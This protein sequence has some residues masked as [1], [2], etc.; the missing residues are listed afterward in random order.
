[1]RTQAWGRSRDEPCLPAVVLTLG[2]ALILLAVVPPA[3]ASAL[4][5]A[6]EE[7]CA[8]RLLVDYAAPLT[9]LPKV[10]EP[11]RSG[12]LT[13]GPP[14]LRF[15]NF[16]RWPGQDWRVVLT[17]ESMVYA[18]WYQA[19][20]WWVGGKRLDWTVDSRLVRV[21]R[22]GRDLRLAERGRERIGVV[23]TQSGGGT[24]YR[25]FG[26][27]APDR[28]GIYRYDLVFRDRHGHLLGRLHD[29]YRVVRRNPES[30][31]IL[32]GTTFRRGDLVLGRVENPGTES[33]SFGAGFEFDRLSGGIWARVPFE[34]LF[35]FPNVVPAIAI[36]LGRGRSGDCRFNSFVV[37]AGMGPGIYRMV[38][39]ADLTAEFTVLP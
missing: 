34:E 18:F 3:A 5:S 23:S 20:F 13:F 32:D 33:V 16:N 22:G 6:Q 25:M 15:Q 14:R 26:L 30:R 24:R 8:P 31:L 12:R 38:K 37:P 27:D 35:G 7:F 11:P 19:P 1:M 9:G 29:Y 10:R 2:A 28:P 21:S 36:Q 17:D 39:S 4:T